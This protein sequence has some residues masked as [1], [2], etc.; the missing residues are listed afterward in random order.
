KNFRSVDLDVAWQ[1][2]QVVMNAR[3]A[4]Y[5]VL[6]LDAQVQRAREANRGLQESTGAMR[7]A[8]NK[9]EKTVLDLSAVESASQDSVVTMLGLVQEFERQRMGLNEALGME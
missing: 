9:Q 8:L 5:R 2:W 3:V 1:E 4:V 7:V 6:A